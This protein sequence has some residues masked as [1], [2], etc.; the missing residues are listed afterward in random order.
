[1]AAANAVAG[2]SVIPPFSPVAD[3]ELIPAQPFVA[4][5]EGSAGAFL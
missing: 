4:I 2:R 1:M 3:G 5:A